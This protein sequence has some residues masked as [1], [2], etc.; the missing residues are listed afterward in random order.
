MSSR[1]TPCLL[2]RTSHLYN[3]VQG[4]EKLMLC[5]RLSDFEAFLAFCVSDV[6]FDFSL[7]FRVALDRKLPD[8]EQHF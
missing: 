5:F 4:L 3:F 8:Q 7:L 1:V 2:S 6:S